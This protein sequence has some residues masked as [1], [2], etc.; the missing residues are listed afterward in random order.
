MK[1]NIL[2]FITFALFLNICVFAQEEPESICE[3][4][5]RVSSIDPAIGRI[6]LT[7]DPYVEQNLCATGFIIPNGKIVTAGHVIA[8]L[9]IEGDWLEFNVKPS[10]P[11]GK[12]QY[13][14]LED[15][16]IIDMN[17]I[18]YQYE[19]PLQSG[20][21]KDWAVFSVFPN[22]ITGLTPIEAQESFKIVKKTNDPG[23]VNIRITG[24][25]KDNG[26]TNHIQ[27]TAIGPYNHNEPNF[28]DF[29][30]YI[31]DTE[32]G[33][34]GSPI[35]DESTGFV[36]GVHCQGQCSGYGW[37]GGTSFTNTEFWNAVNLGDIITIDQKRESGSRLT[38]T[39]ISHYETRFS[40]DS[41]LDYQIPSGSGIPFQFN[42]NNTE[43]FRGLQELVNSPTEK[44]YQWNNLSDVTNHKSFLLNNTVTYY[45]SNFKQVYSNVSI[46]NEY[47]EVQGLNPP[48]DNVDF[49]DPWLID[50]PDPNF[51][52]AKRNRGMKQTGIDALIYKTRLAPFSP[53]FATNYD[54]DVYR[55]VF[56]NQPIE[57]GKPYFSVRSQVQDV[58]L[59]QTNRW[60]KFY[61]YEWTGTNAIFQYP[62][63][64]E[65]AIV[66]TNDNATVT[67][68]LKGTQIS[69]YQ[70]AYSS[71]S[72]RR[73]IQTP[74]G[75]KHI[76]YT[77]MGKVWYELSTNGGSTWII[78]NGG[79]P[80]S[81]VDSKNPAMSFYGNQVGIVWQEQYGISFKIK[82]AVFYGSN[83][84]SSVIDTAAE[85]VLSYSHNA[86]PVIA[87]GYSIAEQ[88][89]VMVA[90]SGAVYGLFYAQGIMMNLG[91]ASSNG[92]S[93]TSQTS[94]T[95]TDANSVN[96]TLAANHLVYT[97]PFIYHLAWEQKINASSSK[98][99]YC[100]AYYQNNLIQHSAIEEPSSNSGYS[101]NYSPLVELR[102]IINYEYVYVTWLGYR[103]SQ[104]EESL[105]KGNA[106]SGGETRVLLKNKYTSWSVLGVYGDNVNNF[107]LN[108]GT[109]IISNVQIIGLAWSETYGSSFT[110]KAI[111]SP[112]TGTIN[113]LNTNGKDLQ[114]NN[115]VNFS[116]MYANSFQSVTSPYSFSLSQNF[117]GLSKENSI[118]LFNGREGI[119]S[120]NDGQFYFA[121]GDVSINGSN[122]DFIPLADSTQFFTAEDINSYFE[123]VSFSVNSSS[124][125]IY[126][127]QYGIT[128]S[129]LCSSVLADGRQIYFKVEL[130]DANNNQTLGLFDEITFTEE[131]VYQ[132]NN[133]GYQMDLTWIGEKTLKLRLVV[134]TNSE[135]DYAIAKRF[136]DQS[137]FLKN[138]LINIKYN[139][140]LVVTEYA[141]EQN[142]PNPFNPATTIKYQ[143]PASGNVT[144]KVYDI[145]G[146]E[147]ATLVNEEKAAGRYEV[148][149]Y[150]S[151]LASGVYIYRLNV[152]DYVSVKKMVL[153]R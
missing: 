94:L 49:K 82:I 44:Y 125:L 141:L 131:N 74:D 15:R 119:V 12:L 146:E 107:G 37:N 83:Y 17:S 139:D 10:L 96:P 20:Y 153:L 8:E 29:H 151:N 22:S 1:S 2:Y 101:K 58:F 14:D 55:G 77:S 93:W 54:E 39:N 16:Y 129:A 130:V 5:D 32:N 122:V 114:I 63:N 24:Y 18:S 103:D 45:T 117:A 47:P 115:S 102:Q 40:D 69:N 135:F 92:I 53:D 133:I 51:G 76:V 123:T 127:V 28:P 113:I 136:S 100:K 21:G 66:F 105:E 7:Y 52:N 152:N 128:D 6:I 137:V 42:K 140:N 78:G 72:Q 41:F 145:L 38:G 34:S 79:K 143:L 73:F 91:F 104:Q 67:A 106:F 43:T 144:L 118:I 109:A 64:N 147:I 70:N 108:K 19:G 81:N 3:P 86:N 116:D 75:V 99:N 138:S 126:G 84:S 62:Y 95:G 85:E 25:G 111:K 89:N 30:K 87:F 48:N 4:D 80:L 9:I 97:N 142:F 132:Y 13:S 27:Q 121:L 149:F 110:N 23:N 88:G 124:V 36:I 112:G 11:D 65:T 46:K 26:T 60:H 68:K 59:S 134:Q 90:W 31:T 120:R 150:V 57:T 61:C 98:I 33:N 35:V 50:Y 56:L 148:N 71:N